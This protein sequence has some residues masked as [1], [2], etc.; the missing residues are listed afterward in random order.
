MK[1]LDYT[2]TAISDHTQDTMT[3]D[4]T[5]VERVKEFNCL[6]S[7]ITTKGDSRK[8]ID[9]RLGIGRSTVGKLQTIWRDKNITGNM[10]LPILKSMVFLITI[11]R[12]ETWTFPKR[13]R[14]RID[15]FEMS[16]AWNILE[17]SHNQRYCTGKSGPQENPASRHPKSTTKIFWSHSRP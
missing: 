16:A 2:S 6:G 14:N 7:Y 10:K 9:R 12:L 4:S 15:S 13:E 11:Y 17:R 8:E 5:N 1:R 3:V